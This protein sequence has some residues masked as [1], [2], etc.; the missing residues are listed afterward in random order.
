M[1][2]DKSQSARILQ[3]KART[4][5][6]F[7]NENPNA[8]IEGP[9]G[10]TPSSTLT[11]M[12]LYQTP[13]LQNSDFKIQIV[14]GNRGLTSKM[15]DSIH[16]NGTQVDFTGIFD[17]GLTKL[18]DGNILIPNSGMV[19]NFFGTN[20]SS[21]M[22]W[23]SN[24]ALTFGPITNLAIVS[25]S[26]DTVPSVLLGNYDRR[27]KTFYYLN[28]IRSS[29]SI[30]TFLI[31]FFDYY[32]AL[33]DDA[34][35]TWRIRLIKENTGSKRQ[36]IEI[37]IDSSTVPS[38]GYSSAIQTYP[39]GNQDSNGDQIDQTKTS[40]FNITNGTNFLNPCGSTFSTTSPLANTS[41]VFSSNRQG[42]KWA[43]KNNAYVNV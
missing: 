2:V 3:I 33:S 5:R 4:L 28:T 40:P 7:H 34:T 1:L 42:T 36:F 41:F 23:N 12:K 18:D 16:T 14:S 39:S 17:N 15:I 32:T 27:L 21:S 25:I 20:Y 35:Y 43:F 31:S 8:Q 22:Y 9:R 38:P 24:N 6:V 37:C 29:Y 30:T 26:K 13:I 11:A 10:T 19:F